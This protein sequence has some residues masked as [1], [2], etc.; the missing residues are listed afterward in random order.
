MIY[1]FYQQADVCCA[2]CSSNVFDFLF[3]KSQFLYKYVPLQANNHRNV[4][5]LHHVNDLLSSKWIF[6]QNMLIYVSAERVC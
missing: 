4:L 6:E 3:T 2:A 5:A 1:G